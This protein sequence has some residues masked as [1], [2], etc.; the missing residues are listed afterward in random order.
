M[1]AGAAILAGFLLSHLTVIVIDHVVHRWPIEPG[2]LLYSMRHLTHYH[3]EICSFGVTTD[4]WDIVFRT[5]ARLTGRGIH[6]AV[7]KVCVRHRPSRSARPP[8]RA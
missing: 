1:Q 2:S 7:G 3:L 8:Q 5:Y 4:V 6:P